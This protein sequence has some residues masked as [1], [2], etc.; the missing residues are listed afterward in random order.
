MALS[1]PLLHEGSGPML[2]VLLRDDAYTLK[3]YFI[4]PSVKIISQRRNKF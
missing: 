4:K 1:P 3:T 2:Y